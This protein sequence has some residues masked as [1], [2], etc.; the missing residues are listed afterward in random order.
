MQSS[1]KDEFCVGHSTFEGSE[2][3]VWEELSGVRLCL[4][5]GALH[6]AKQAEEEP[7]KGQEVGGGTAVEE[8]PRCRFVETKATEGPKASALA[9]Q[10][11]VQSAHTSTA[12]PRVV[13]K[14]R[15]H[16]FLTGLLS[17]S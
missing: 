1:E 2:R 14:A 11:E 7:G 12:V 8:E 15:S 16:L 5:E 4:G 3:Q 17:F 13:P 9:Q 6:A 10:L